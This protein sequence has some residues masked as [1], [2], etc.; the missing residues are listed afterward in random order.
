MSIFTDGHDLT[1]THERMFNEIR[2]ANPELPIVMMSMPKFT[3]SNVEVERY[4]IIKK[5]YDNA[6]SRG[7]KNV[8]LI[9]GRD[10]MQYAMNDGTVDNCHPNDIGF[11]S[12]AKTIIP[13]LEEILK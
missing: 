1:N 11:F 12:M 7:D 6:V 5:T 4:E 2:Q 9:D 8:Y 10:L 3:L 13:V